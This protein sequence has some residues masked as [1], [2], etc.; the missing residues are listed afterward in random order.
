MLASYLHLMLEKYEMVLNE[1][2]MGYD[3]LFDIDIAFCDTTDINAFEKEMNSK[4]DSTH[5]LKEE[6]S[7]I[8]SQKNILNEEEYKKKID[9][10][11][12]KLKN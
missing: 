12:K 6:E 3:R 8:I 4:S 5:E 1:L 9:N 11:K 7:K 10:L 2:S